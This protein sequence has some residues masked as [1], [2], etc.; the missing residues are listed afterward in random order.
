MEKVY[1]FDMDGTL[2]DSMPYFSGGVLALLDAEGLSYP[3]DIVKIVTPL[4]Y[5][6]TARYLVNMGAKRQEQELVQAMGDYLF[7]A[8]Q[9]EIPLKPGVRDCLLR[10]KAAGS[11]LAV[12]T[13]SPHRVTDPCLKRNGVWELFDRVWSTDD[14]GLTKSQPEIFIRAAREL[15]V[16]PEDVVFFDDNLGAL[17]T[18]KKAGMTTVGVYDASSDDYADRIRSIVDRYLVDYGEY[19]SLS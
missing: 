16:Q 5:A 9:N 12:L 2:I 3:P 1:L 8:Y 13:A 4:G 15:G 10:L 19:F 7:H 18:A 6:G 14:F 11:R 17:E